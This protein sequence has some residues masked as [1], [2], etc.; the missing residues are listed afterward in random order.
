MTIEKLRIELLL[1]L[2]AVTPVLVSPAR[3]AQCVVQQDELEV[4]AAFLKDSSS[5]AQPDVVVTR[6]FSAVD[7]D[8]ANLQ[9]AVKGQGI[10]TAVRQDFK[11]KAASECGIPRTLAAKG[12]KFLSPRDQ[13]EM[14]HGRSGWKTF[15]RRFGANASLT[16]FSRV[17][18]NPEHTLALVFV[19]SGIEAMAGSGFVYVFERKDGHWTKKSEMQAWTT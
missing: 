10:P 18:L 16:T 8:S 13:D 4:I 12:V 11:K 3:A 5:S 17:G 14:F 6:T 2:V 9:L 19:T 15:H 1:L 7:I